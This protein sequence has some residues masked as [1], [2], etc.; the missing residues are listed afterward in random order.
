MFLESSS[1]DILALCKTNLNDSIDSRNFS[2]S[3]YLSLIQKDLVTDM[4]DLAVYVKQGFPFARGLSL[5][6]SEHSYSCFRLALL[7]S[8]SYF[9]DLYLSTYFSLC[10]GFDDMSSNIAEAFSV[11]QSTNLFV[12]GDFNVHL[13]GWLNCSGGSDRLVN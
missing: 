11:N 6:N 5:E 13:K 9:F 3:G 1:P 12:F 7:L 10:T 8:V 2:V 4:H